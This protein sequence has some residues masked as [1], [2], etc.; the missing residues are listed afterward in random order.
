MGDALSG[1]LEVGFWSFYI[2][3][4]EIISTACHRP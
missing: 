2:P 3:R 1:S 4:I